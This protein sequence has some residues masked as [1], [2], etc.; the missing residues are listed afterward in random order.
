SAAIKLP[1]RSNARPSAIGR[2][3]L[4]FHYEAGP[5]T[6]LGGPNDVT[7]SGVFAQ[8]FNQYF[9]VF[10]LK[11]KFVEES[12]FARTVTMRWIEQIIGDLFLLDDQPIKIRQLHLAASS[13]I[14]ISSALKS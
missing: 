11:S 12:C 8:C 5:E 6:G 9:P 4:S 7:R 14:L 3:N 1:D 13:T 2:E 10:S